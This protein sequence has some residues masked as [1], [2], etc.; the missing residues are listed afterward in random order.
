MS[1][2]LPVL[3]MQ[4]SAPAGT[5]GALEF[6]TNLRL[7][8]AQ[9]PRTQLVIY[10]ELHLC[11]AVT[12]AAVESEAEPAD[13]PRETFLRQLAADLGV[14]LIPGTVY[15]RDDQG[16]VYNTALAISPTGQ[17]AARYR[18]CFPWRPYETVTPG[19]EFVVFDIPGLT[20]VGLSICYDTWFPEL[21]RHLAWMGAEVI[22]QPTLTPTIDRAQELILSQATAIE[23]QVFVI[24][25]NSAA[26]QAT[27]QSMIVNPEGHVLARAGE[28]PIA[29]THVLNLDDAQ[30]AREFGTA[31][32][33]RVWAQF[34]PGDRPIPLPLYGG[35]LDPQRWAPNIP[36]P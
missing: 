18:K 22:V 24:S 11:P 32:I 13:G 6:E 17:I 23:N 7:Q 29:L 10:P 35:Q 3:I 9:F 19:V 21:A 27:G 14:W 28:G 25:V 20:R 34:I 16:R 4:Y 12:A 30:G 26:P 2:H 31:G 5:S 36:T 1:R 8:L 33:T 15:E